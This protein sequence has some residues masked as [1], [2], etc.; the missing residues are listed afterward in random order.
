VPRDPQ[1]VAVRAK[2][3]F[4]AAGAAAMYFFDPSQ[5]RA[6]RGRIQQKL[7]AVRQKGEQATAPAADVVDVRDEAAAVFAPMPPVDLPS[8]PAVSSFPTG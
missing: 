3:L 5:G 7:G 8:D 2:L 6:R 1:E 4:A